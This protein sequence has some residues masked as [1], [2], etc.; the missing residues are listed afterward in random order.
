MRNFLISIFVP[1]YNGEKYLTTCIDSILA[2]TYK[3][4]ELIL[5]ND[6]SSD[7]SEIICQN[8]AERDNRV[9][10]FNYEH[11]SFRKMF[12]DFFEIASGEYIAQ[13]DDDDY[14]APDFLEIL[15]KSIIEQKAEVAICSYLNVDEL[16]KNLEL[17]PPLPVNDIV[18]Y[19][20]DALKKYLTTLE[21]EGFRWN[22]LFKK[23]IYTENNI[24]FVNTYPGDIPFKFDILSKCKVASFV[25]KRLYF[26]RKTTSSDTNNMNLLKYRGFLD[27][28]DRVADKAAKLGLEKEANYFRIWRKNNTLYCIFRLGI[29][30]KI[31]LKELKKE[32]SWKRDIGINIFSALKILL[33]FKDEI[34]G[35]LKLIV[36]TILVR[37]FL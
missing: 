11:G 14:V 26:Y 17:Q 33:E 2:Q 4:F 23:T 16:G 36:K 35:P 5:M 9:K 28:F 22:M 13:I 34:N 10:L 8:Y 37:I 12:P 19:E 25:A 32:F 3:N 30:N 7:D 29:K 31:R 15:Y 1:V 27:T 21:I 20:F 24:S 18:L 6:G